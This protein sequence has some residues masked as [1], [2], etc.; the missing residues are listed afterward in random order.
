M[1][2]VGDGMWS[3]ILLMSRLPG[4]RSMMDNELIVNL[5]PLKTRLFEHCYFVFSETLASTLEVTWLYGPYKLN[6]LPSILYYV[7][8]SYFSA[9]CWPCWRRYSNLAVEPADS[10]RPAARAALSEVGRNC[11]LAAASLPA[12]L[13]RSAAVPRSH[14]SLVAPRR[15]TRS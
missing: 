6:W 4:G 12:G 9:P 14:W 5:W 8:V 10:R 7:A 13:T 3:V 11:R 15:C 1:S 2:W